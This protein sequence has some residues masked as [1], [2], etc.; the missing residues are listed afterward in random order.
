MYQVRS[1]TTPER[2]AITTHHASRYQAE[3]ERRS[4]EERGDYNA[5]LVPS[6][7]HPLRHKMTYNDDRGVCLAIRC[8]S[9]GMITNFNL[10]AEM[11]VSMYT[12][13]AV[14][15]VPSTVEEVA[16]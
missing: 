2:V 15:Y 16:A 8:D 11:A 5:M 10:P 13:L 12:I 7:S 9:C 6:C 1:I 4:R 3:L 14:E